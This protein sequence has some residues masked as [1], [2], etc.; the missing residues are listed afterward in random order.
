[1]IFYC[2]QTKEILQQSPEDRIPGQI[3]ALIQ[4]NLEVDYEKLKEFCISNL[5]TYLFEEEETEETS[6]PD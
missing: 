6:E 3:K 2:L 1:M 4:M 5:N